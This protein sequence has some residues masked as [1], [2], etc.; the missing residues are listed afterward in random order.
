MKK[1]A[2]HYDT[3]LKGH[4]SVTSLNFLF[5]FQVNCPGCFL[6]GIP[7][8]NE[9]YKEF[10][11]EISFLGLST[12]FEDFDLNTKENT[13]RLLTKNEVVGE[14]KRALLHHGLDSYPYS[15]DFPIAMDKKADASFDYGKAA[16]QIC[17]G[18]ERYNKAPKT[19]QKDF[20]INVTHY[21]KHQSELSMTFTLNQMRGTPTLLVFND[22]YDILYHQFGHTEHQIVQR[23]LEELIENTK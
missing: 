16:E 4:F 19:E 8:I 13:Q 5:V 15:I 12:S 22:Q 7:L 3:P 6:Y 17:L 21:L 14:T 10:G 9:L 2:L 18:S 20:L 1:L 11:Q 23:H